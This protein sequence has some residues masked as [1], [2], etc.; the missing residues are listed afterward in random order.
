MNNLY[1]TFLVPL[2]K[3]EGGTAEVYLGVSQPN[4]V[5]IKGPIA[6]KDLHRKEDVLSN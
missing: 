3:L 5:K 2:G 4:Q 6:H 1:E